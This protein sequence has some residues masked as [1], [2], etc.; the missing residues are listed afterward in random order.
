MKYCIN[1]QEKDVRK[2]MYILEK[3]EQSCYFKQ[4]QEHKAIT[5][6]KQQN[7]KTCFLWHTWL[8]LTKYLYQIY[9]NKW[10]RYLCSRLIEE[11]LHLE[12]RIIENG[13]KMSDISRRKHPR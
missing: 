13:R 1:V 4:N 6:L 3:H 5:M 2:I 8:S 10:V 9:C 7:T 11:G 12:N